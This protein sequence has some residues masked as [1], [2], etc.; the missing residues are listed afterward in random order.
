MRQDLYFRLSQAT[1][2]L[3]PLRQHHSGLAALCIYFESNGIPLPSRIDRFER[4][5]APAIQSL[6]PVRELQNMLRSL[7]VNCPVGRLIQCAEL[8]DEPELLRSVPADGSSAQ[9]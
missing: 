1:V 9:F 4:L 7:Y 8:P 2:M 5:G 3:P 6:C